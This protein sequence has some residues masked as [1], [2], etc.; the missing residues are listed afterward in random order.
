[1][2]SV[3][4]VHSPSEK[5]EFSRWASAFHGGIT[6]LKQLLPFLIFIKLGKRFVDIVFITVSHV[7]RFAIILKAF[8]HLSKVGIISSSSQH[9]KSLL[10]D[11]I[12]G[13]GALLGGVALADCW[14]DLTHDCVENVG[15]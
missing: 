3:F 7:Y 4:P 14:R 9:G 1:M 13:G 5:P 12:H 15:L 10:D 2:K 11:N 6:S 8:S